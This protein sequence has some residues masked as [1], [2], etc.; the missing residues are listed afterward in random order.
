[1]TA[2]RAAKPPRGMR[3]FLPQELRRRRDITDRIA[4]T[5][6]QYG[7]EPIQTPAMEYLSVLLGKGGNENEKLL[8]KILKRGQKLKQSL[9]GGA[10]E[11]ADLGLRYD[12][13]VPLSRFIA[14]NHGRLP[15]ILRAYNSGPVWR[16]DRPQKGRFREF[17]Q[18]DIDIIGADSEVYDMEILSAS[19]AALHSVGLNQARFRVS[20]CM[21]LP[22]VLGALGVTSG[23]LAASIGAIDK[24]R[25]S[26]FENVAREIRDAVE[27]AG[28][29]NRVL[30]FVAG[31]DA[32]RVAGIEDFLAR[33]PAVV[34]A[35]PL[36]GPL[37]RLRRIVE[38]VRAIHPD[39]GIWFDP[40]L[41]RGMDYYTSTV[42]EAEVPGYSFS[43]AGGGR[44][45]G[46]IGRFAKDSL[47]AVGCSLGYERI[48]TVLLDLGAGALA[49]TP[50]LRWIEPS[51][52]PLER[53][54]SAARVRRPGLALSVELSE[55]N[56]GKATKRAA[57]E[58]I[59]FAVLGWRGEE[60]LLL[61]DLG[62]Q[63]DLEVAPDELPDSLAGRLN[64]PAAR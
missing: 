19:E 8:F 64:A 59:R 18:F 55:D 47:P 20:D 14:T 51:V 42:F 21:I 38:G 63:S 33:L 31:L 41:V 56:L 27:D 36:R 9:G 57:A 60:C 24:I 1:M 7:F 3:D 26:S 61:R 44:Y 29:A 10:D 15:R 45:D 34:P 49:G 54:R 43:V 16:A 25:K 46:L 58:D 32:D 35:E 13:T 62:D 17:L 12:L 28:R 22:H 37:E 50:R 6:E 11:L 4:A 30:E 39:S 53:L 40:S 2:Q 5:Y 23:A 48:D 52:P